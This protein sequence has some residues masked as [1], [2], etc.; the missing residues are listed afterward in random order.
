MTE[1][2][3]LALKDLRIL[4]RDKAGFFFVFFFPLIMAVFFGTIFRSGGGGSG[5]RIQVVDEDQTTQSEN[6]IVKLEEA[7]ELRVTRSTRDEA[8]DLVRRGKTTAYLVLL[9]GFGNA[10]TAGF[11]GPAPPIELGVDPSRQAAAGMLQGILSSHAAERFSQMF[12][13]GSGPSVEPLS[14]R[15]Q[16]VEVKRVFPTNSYSVSFP[17]GIVWAFLGAAASFG[18]SLVVERRRGTLKRLHMAPVSR[19]QILAG[20]GLA[21]FIITAAVASILMV[22]AVVVFGVRPNYLNLALA[23]LSGSIGFVGIMMLVSVMGRTEQSSSGIGWAILLLMSMT[24]GGMIPMMIMPSWLQTASNFSPVKWLVLSMEGAL[25]RQFTLGEMLM[26][27]GILV[28][29]GLVFFAL[30]VKVFNF[31]YQE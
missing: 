25:W 28:G 16:D 23:I 26:P 24:G 3:A 18:V 6:F 8:V 4:L 1:I 11:G 30:G 5:I 31:T 7:P 9:E 19:A 13:G 27:C 17:Q 15:K 2:A 29:V 20:K 12:G 14:I 10:W 22:I 21:C